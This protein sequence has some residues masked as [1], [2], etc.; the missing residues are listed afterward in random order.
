MAR[1]PPPEVPR[2]DLTPEAL[3]LWFTRFKAW[4]KE[5]QDHQVTAEA[6]IAALEV[7]TGVVAPA[8]ADGTDFGS[9][10]HKPGNSSL[11]P[12]NVAGAAVGGQVSAYVAWT[13]LANTLVAVPFIAPRRGGIISDL[14]WDSGVATGNARVAVYSNLAD[15][16]LYPNALLGETGSKANLATTVMS[17]TGLTLGPLTAGELYWLAINTDNAAAQF[18]ALNVAAVHSLL[19]IPFGLVSG[20]ACITVASAYGA[21]PS[22]FPAG[23]AYQSTTANQTPALGYKVS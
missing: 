9:F 1:T 20:N 17:T 23:G 8:A 15:D 22:T 13:G 14:A 18:R 5:L 2:G 10:R 6:D 11:S 7:I 19:G 4:A 16:N 21:P 12:W 3:G